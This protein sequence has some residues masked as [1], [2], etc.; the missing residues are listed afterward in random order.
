MSLV[1]V[2]MMELILLLV[3]ETPSPLLTRLLQHVEGEGGV[4][5]ALLPGRH[6]VGPSEHRLR[7]QLRVRVSKGERLG[8]DLPEKTTTK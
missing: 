3:P 7:D 2:H 8:H 5:V 1:V 4:H 6:H